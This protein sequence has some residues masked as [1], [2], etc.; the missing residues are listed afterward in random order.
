MFCKEKDSG[1]DDQINYMLVF[2]YEEIY[3]PEIKDFVY[4]TG[5]INI[6]GVFFHWASPKKN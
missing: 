4:I 1:N 2:R 6:Q 3:A 5:Q